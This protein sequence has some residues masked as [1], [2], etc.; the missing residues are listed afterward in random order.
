MQCQALNL[1]YM[2]LLTQL[3]G[4]MAV[5]TDEQDRPGQDRDLDCTR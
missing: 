3:V 4:G 2:F 1:K 5:T